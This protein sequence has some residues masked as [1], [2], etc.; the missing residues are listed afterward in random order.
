MRDTVPVLQPLSHRIR[1]HER[2]RSV[3]FVFIRVA[4]DGCIQQVLGVSVFLPEFFDV[5]AR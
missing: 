1:I 4:P 2:Q 3:Q 5:F